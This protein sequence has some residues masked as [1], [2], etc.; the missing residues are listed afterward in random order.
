MRSLEILVN[1]V[2][3][4]A[5]IRLRDTPAGVYVG[6]RFNPEVDLA[7]FNVVWGF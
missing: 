7:P 6:A 1:E 4:I 2:L 5:G 3:C